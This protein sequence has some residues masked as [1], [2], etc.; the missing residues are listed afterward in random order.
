MK[1]IYVNWLG[2]GIV[3]V[4]WEVNVDVIIIGLCGIGKFRWIFL[5][6]VSDYV[7]YY[8]DVFVIVCCYKDFYDM[9]YYY[10]DYYY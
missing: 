10:E 8:F 7:L 5:G 2:E 6:S 3:N 1:S 9:Y 4:V